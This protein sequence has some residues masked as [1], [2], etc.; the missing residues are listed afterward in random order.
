MEVVVLIAVKGAI[1]DVA[2]SWTREREGGEGGRV[3]T[4]ERELCKLYLTWGI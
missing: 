3:R 2:G 4:E 1:V